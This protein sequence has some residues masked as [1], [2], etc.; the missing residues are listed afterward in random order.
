[1]RKVLVDR[2]VIVIVTYRRQR[3]LTRLLDSLLRL[4]TPPWRVVIV[5][6]ENSPQV[7]ALVEEHRLKVEREQ[8]AQ[9]WPGAARSFVYAPQQENT[10]GAG[11][12]FEG[13]RIAF[14]MGA[15]WFWLMDDDVTVLPGALDDL[16][17]WMPDHGVVQGSRLDYDGGPFYWQYR[18]SPRLG[19]YNPFATA[20]FDE[21]GAKE[22]NAACFEGGLFSRA[23]VEQIGLPDYRFFIYWDD[24]VYGYLASKVT[25]SVVVSDEIL[26]RTRDV[27]N[28]EVSG[29][30]QLNSASDVTR[31]YIMRNRGY[32]ARYLQ[33]H[34]DFNR[35][36]FGVGT[37]LSFAKE[38]IRL[39]AVDRKNFSSGTKRLFSGW[40]ASRTLLHDP[41]WKPMPSLDD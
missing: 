25:R 32:M 39:I 15:D 6:N 34:G 1:M 3:L 31:F 41:D 20:H 40:R 17:R 14:D 10:G 13:M 16:A 19:I 35:F 18:F 30:R 9:V 36:L 4:S 7:E 28:W 21:S 24:C 12:F 11:G 27:R 26:Q 22:T 38:L 23:V 8:T 5:D 29:T 33:L 37:F 2:V